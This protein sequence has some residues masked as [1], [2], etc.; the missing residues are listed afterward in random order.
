MVG[1]RFIDS[2]VKILLTRKQKASSILLTKKQKENEYVKSIDKM[3]TNI[4]IAAWA[5]AL[6]AITPMLDATM[7]NIAIKDLTQDFHTT[8]SIIQWGVTGYLLALAIAVPI[9]GWLMNQFN[10]KRVFISAVV[11][12]GITSLAT[13][14]SWN[15]VTFIS[16]RLL[17]GFSAGVITTLMSTMLV[18][19]AAQKYIGRV[20]AIVSTPMILGPILGPVLGGLIIHFATWQ[21][22]FFINIFVTIIAVPIMIKKLPDFNPVN[23]EKKLDYIGVINLALISVTLLYGLV[24][25]SKFG[26]FN[27]PVTY[28]NMTIGVNCI[29]VYIIYNRMKQ[30]NTVLPTNLFKS[31]NFFACSLGLFLANVAILGPMIILPLF[32][33]RFQHFNAIETAIMLM[34][35][36][37]GML[38]TRPLIGKI[39]DKYGGRNIVLISTMVVLITSVSFMFISGHT[40]SVWIGLILFIRGC[41]VGGVMLPLT[42]S[43][44]YGLEREQ[45][46]EAGVGI[47]IIENI[48]SS[49]G[50]ALIATVVATVIHSMSVNIPNELTAYHAGFSVAVI[51]LVVLLLPAWF[52]HQK[53]INHSLQKNLCH[54]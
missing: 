44:Y 12:F 32:F 45:L 3:P 52:I 39:I 24:Q 28:I 20:I 4:M 10:S 41:A 6:G 49:F 2:C 1:E 33:Q 40:Q 42:S 38:I 37:S 30:Y 22:I 5:I 26:S 8:L 9:S 54:K 48:G 17:Q 34:P 14:L 47:N 13:G 18:L 27:N 7:I 46:S 43:A 15:I 11:G 36:G 25:V 31:R 53:I 21:W 35:Q 50:S 29:I 19:I 51:A 16:F 23:K